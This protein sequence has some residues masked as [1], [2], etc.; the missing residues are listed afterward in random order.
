MCCKF[1]VYLN[2]ERVSI[3]RIFS[4]IYTKVTIISNLVSV[5]H[6]PSNFAITPAPA[7]FA[8]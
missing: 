2:F 7:T 3:L 6:K 4:F 5:Y 1:L 8:W